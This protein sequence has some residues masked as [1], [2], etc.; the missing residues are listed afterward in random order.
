MTEPFAP[1]LPCPF[2]GK[3][4]VMLEERD[5]TDGFVRATAIRCDECGIEM[6]EEYRSEVT[7]VWNHRSPLHHRVEPRDMTKDEER[8]VMMALDASSPVISDFDASTWGV[9]P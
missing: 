4:P 7:E 3:P 2:C 6:S 8:L 5:M 1:L 9:K